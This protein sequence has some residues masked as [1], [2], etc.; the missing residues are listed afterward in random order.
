MTEKPTF[1]RVLYTP[2]NLKDWIEGRY[3]SGHQSPTDWFQTWNTTGSTELEHYPLRCSTGYYSGKARSVFLKA[4]GEGRLDKLTEEESKLICELDGVCAWDT[5]QGAY[6]YLVPESP[7][8]KDNFD[9]YVEF[10]GEKLDDDTVEGKGAVIA[11]VIQAVGE[12]LSREEF[13]RIHGVQG[14]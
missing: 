12:A 13:R 3:H 7:A 9:K 4:A 5:P 14:N 8:R 10:L 2:E 6:A 1:Y 11:R